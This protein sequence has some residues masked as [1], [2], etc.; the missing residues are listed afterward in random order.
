MPFSFLQ[1]FLAGIAVLFFLNTFSKFLKGESGQTRF[2]LFLSLSI[3]GGVFT[4]SLFPKLGTLLSEHLGLGNNLN[5]LIFL[6]FV[7][8]FIILF[9]IL[10]LIERVERD[11]SEI[12]RKDALREIFTEKK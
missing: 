10:H 5:T 9:K 12:V 11:I 1:I 2:K 8:V 6:G 4:L 7:I 3:W